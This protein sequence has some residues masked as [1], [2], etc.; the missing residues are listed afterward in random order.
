VTKI[1]G[2]SI[3][4]P[5]S[6]SAAFAGAVAASTPGLIPYITAGFPELNDTGRILSEFEAAGCI[7]A[8]IGIP[9]TDPLADGPTIQRTGRVAIENGMTLQLGLHQAK[10]ARAAGLSIPLAVMTYFNLIH[11]YGVER[12][13]IDAV[14]SG[15]D[16]VIV[17]DLPLA[18]SHFLRA[19]C[20]LAGLAFIPMVAP[21]TSDKRIQ[22]TCRD[23]SGFV[24]CVSVTGTTGAREDVGKEAFDLLERVRRATSLPR[25]LGFGISRR[26]HI[27]SLRGACEAVIVASALLDANWASTGDA[28]V[29]VA[30][31]LDGMLH[32][33][34]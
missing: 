18:E 25:A 21:T 29:T 33:S 12:F 27:E 17:P 3:R 8:E 23:V 5:G 1:N 11:K 19:T 6:V 2:Q 34:P 15:V 31:F 4:K 24:Y 14:D 28:A 32:G 13:V 9:H 16:S 7:A 30:R 10:D 20:R 26:A 22:E